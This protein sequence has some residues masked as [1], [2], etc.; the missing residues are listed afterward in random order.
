MSENVYPVA[1]SLLCCAAVLEVFDRAALAALSPHDQKEMTD[2]LLGAFVLPADEFP[3]TY[4]LQEVVRQETL[5]QLRATAPAQEH[6][7]HER[8]F[9][10]FLERMRH[11]QHADERMFAERRCFYHLDALRAPLI[12]QRAWTRIRAYV[13]AVRAN[14]PLLPRHAHL[15]MVYDGLDAIRTQRYAA[16]EA[17]LA[18][19]LA[20]PHVDADL[21]MRAL[22]IL[23][24]SYW[25][26]SRYDRA[27]ELYRQVF[28]RAEVVGNRVFAAHA[29]LNQ[30]MVY[31]EIEQYVQAQALSS[32]SLE[33]YRAL[34]DL[35]HT[36]H[37]LYEIA[38]NAT[39]R[40]RW[41]EADSY[42]QESAAIYQRLGQQA[43]LANVFMLQARLAL[44]LGDDVA[45]ESLLQ[46]SLAIGESPDIGDLA[47]T[48]DAWLYLGLLYQSQERW[49]EAIGA[50]DRAR[51]TAQSLGN[52]HSLA[53]ACFRRGDVLRTQGFTQSALVAYREAIDLLESL[54]DTAQLEEVKLGM[55]GAAQQIYEAAVL[56]LHKH[57]QHVEAY[58]VVE[59]AR[60]R[61]LLDMLARKA[62]A[63][64]AAFDQPVA[65]LAEVQAGLPEDAVLVEFYTT[66]VL[67]LGE[68][69]TYQLQNPRLLKQL[70]LPPNILIFIISRNDCVV[71][72]APID[73]NLLRLQGDVRRSSQRWLHNRQ[74]HALYDA[75]IT[76]VAD[77]IAGYKQLFIVPHGPLHHVPFL[78]F[79]SPSGHYLLE[80]DGP[81]VAFAPSATILLRNCFAQQPLENGSFLALGYNDPRAALHHAEGEA[82][83]VAHFTGGTALLGPQAKS[84]S[85]ADFD[86]QLRGLHIAGHAVYQADDPLGSYIMLGADD[87]L[88]ARAVME[89][90][91]L[92]ATLVTLSACTSGLSRVAPGDELLGLLRSWLYAGAS[93][94]VCALWDAADIPTRL[95]IEQFYSI[96]QSGASPGIAFLNA[97]VATRDITGRE[98]EG[99]FANWREADS[100]VP[101]PVINPDL[102][103]LRPY[104]DPQVWAPFVLFG[105]P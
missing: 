78:A 69:L 9:A 27:L 8:A 4:R 36:A 6:V 55:L 79:R 23:A 40:G 43:Q 25:F 97:I 44:G 46:R 96:L 85:L 68:H 61:A 1:F 92:R 41:H 14:E 10:A 11:A 54:R 84:Q 32:Q 101:L 59:R 74:L 103:D 13:D 95:I 80:K 31:H 52:T 7:L 100:T 28:E 35:V 5:E 81:V 102:Y 37:A 83:A 62:P 63:L 26:Q 105:R 77:L 82:R 65:T 73:P 45:C 47:I 16:G 17:V 29:L 21:H 2:L 39:I 53:L 87:P 19:L 67:P 72:T 88:S 70:T 60:S 3:E 42:F 49:D 75:L 90:L 86:S 91:N 18:G 30:S 71:R 98:L 22:N 99:I 56:L 38:K 66:G 104:S 24:Q 76:P 89:Q 33:I 57:N 93:T 50:Y 94:V 15:L 64:Y 48:M 20:L 12:E 51:T 58:H 34:G